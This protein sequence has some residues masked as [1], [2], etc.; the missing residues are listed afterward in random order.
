M[1]ISRVNVSGTLMRD[2]Q[3]AVRDLYQRA[4]AGI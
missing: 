4:T 1:Q 2:D 3:R